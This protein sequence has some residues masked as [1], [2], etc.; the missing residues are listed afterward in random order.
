MR[1]CPA[2]SIAKLEADLK[3]MG[4][5]VN[6]GRG[7][8]LHLILTL[9]RRLEEAFGKIVD[10]KKDGGWRLVNRLQRRGR[11]R[12]G[13]RCGRI[14]RHRLIPTLCRRLEEAFVKI[15]DGKKD[16]GGWGTEIRALGPG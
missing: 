1:A 13:I 6:Y 16:G 5:D 9:C 7:S 10:G 11:A 4:G 15:V 8:M 3:A 14:P 12:S 2:C